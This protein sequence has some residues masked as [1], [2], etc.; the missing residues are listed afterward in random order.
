[1]I[2]PATALSDGPNAWPIEQLLP[3]L[4]DLLAIDQVSKQSRSFS[5]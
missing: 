4:E 2:D 3:L 5:I 1:H